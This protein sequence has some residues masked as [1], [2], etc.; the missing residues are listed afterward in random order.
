MTTEMFSLAFLMRHLYFIAPLIS[1]FLILYAWPK[2]R[3]P[4]V[5]AFMALMASATVY[6]LAYT[7]QGFCDTHEMLRFWNRV[8]YIGIATLPSFWLMLAFRY[9]GRD[10]WTVG[11]IRVALIG[12]PTLTLLF[13]FTTE[14]HGLYYAATDIARSEGI[15]RLTFTPGPWYYLH[16]AYINIAAMVG[17]LLLIELIMSAKDAS[18]R[19][20]ALLMLSGA[21]APW[22]AYGFYQSGHTPWG[23]DTGP[24]GVVASGLFYAAGLFRLGMLDIVPIARERVFD[25]IAE[26]VIVFDMRDRLVDYNTAA[27]MILPALAKTPIGTPVSEVLSVFPLLVEQVSTGLPGVDIELNDG[28]TT[29]YF[30]ARFAP[31]TSR[32][33]KKV[34][35][36]LM[37]SD[38]TDRELLMR[39]LEQIAVFDGLTGLHNRRSLMEQFDKELS[40]AKRHKRPLSL[41]M[42][43][44]D[45][46]KK[47]NDEHGHLAGD[48][49]LRAVSAACIETVRGHDF[50]GRYGGEEIAILLPETGMENAVMIAER[51]RQKIADIAVTHGEMIIRSTASFGVASLD[52]L[53]TANVDGLIQAAD[54][55]LYRAKGEGRNCVRTA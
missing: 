31:I 22:I 12:M 30:Y 17:V 53:E 14:W 29:R 45:H 54:T 47:T 23:L 39:R 32:F 34:G 37:L 38:V 26:A 10:H 27:S 24:F 7:L 20:R 4:V 11:W 50:I 48:A 6:T 55:A 43:D 2:R 18:S 3:L 5:Q 33:G 40:R 1:F 8:E 15:I 42:I 44:L 51:I 28:R 21:V 41:I 19:K 36:T 9:T 35:G 13:N 25:A 52:R 49:V 46:F 16:N